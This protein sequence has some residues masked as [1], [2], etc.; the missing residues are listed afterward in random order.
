MRNV[1][2]YE[3][4]TV[5][6]KDVSYY[7][8]LQNIKMKIFAKIRDNLWKFFQTVRYIVQESVEGIALPFV[9]SDNY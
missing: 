8:H 2:I 1:M 9:H 7:N 5:V 6:N 3:D 4:T